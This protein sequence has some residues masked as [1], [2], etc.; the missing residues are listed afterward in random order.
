[1]PHSSITMTPQ[2]QS[3]HPHIPSLGSASGSAAVSNG[4]GSG[5]VQAQGQEEH[6]VS[7]LH[8]ALHS[9]SGEHD[10][11]SPGGTAQVPVPVPTYTPRS[12]GPSPRDDKKAHPISLDISVANDQ[13]YLRGTGVDVEPTL[14]TGNVV[15]H[16]SEPTSIKQIVLVFRGKAR[17]PNNPHDPYVSSLFLFIHPSSLFLHGSAPL[18]HRCK[19]GGKVP[20]LTFP[21]S[22]SSRIL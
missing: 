8:A 5:N 1:M 9:L 14:L 11:V 13:L 4:G 20:S 3:S 7:A 6:L 2:R 12:D 18:L 10:R 22:R 16:L 15:L 17:V 19:Q 21:S